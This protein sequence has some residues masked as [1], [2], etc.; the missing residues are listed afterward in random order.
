MSPYHVDYWGSDP[1][2]GNDDCW[3]GYDFSS[4]EEARAKFAADPDAYHYNCTAVIVLDGP[5]IHE[6]RK[7]LGFRPSKNNDDAEWRSESVTQAGMMGGC[8]SANDEAEV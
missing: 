8:D 2:E 7:H 6:E 1:D 3:T 5:E 4:L